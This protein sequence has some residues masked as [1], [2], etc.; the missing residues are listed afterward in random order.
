MATDHKII[1]DMDILMGNPESLERFHECANLMIIASTPE[2]VQLGYNMLEIV[3]DCMSQL[4]KVA[5]T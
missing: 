4:N 2:Q 3:D 5:D 1:I